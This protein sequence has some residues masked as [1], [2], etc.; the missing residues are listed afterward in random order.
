MLKQALERLPPALRLQLLSNTI[1]VI[2]DRD[3]LSVAAV[4]ST[5]L[6]MSDKATSLVFEFNSE[7]EMAAAKAAVLA[8]PKDSPMEVFDAA[9]HAVIALHRA[10]KHN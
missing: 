3:G 10:A 9:V 8:L 1:Q 7:S 4:L 5:L 6:Q 2:A